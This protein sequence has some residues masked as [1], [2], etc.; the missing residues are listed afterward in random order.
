MH[1]QL[2]IPAIFLTMAACQ[3]GPKPNQPADSTAATTG[4]ATTLPD[5]W[6]KR[7]K[8]TI[9]G[10]SVTLLLQKAAPADYRGWYVYDA[11]GEPIALRPFYGETRTD[12]SIIVNEGYTDEDGVI[13]GHLGADGHFKGKWVNTKNNYDFDLTENNDSAITFSVVAFSDST[14]LLPDHPNSPSATASSYTVWPTG[15]ANEG[16]LSFLKR[17]I[18]PGLKSGETPASLLKNGADS[19]FTSYKSNASTI[20]SASMNNGPSW[21]W[22]TQS[23]SVVTW[24][25]WPILV[26]E[27]WV[28][29]FTG[30]AHGNGGSMF[31][32]YDLSKQRKLRLADVFKPN[33]KSVLTAALDK[34]YRKKYKVPASQS[35]TEGGLFVKKIEPNSNFFITSRGAVFSYTPYEIAAYAVGQ[36]TLFVPWEDIKTVVQPDYLR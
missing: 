29:E 19:F 28:Y 12:D 4:P 24:N 22:S 13:R 10:Q 6:A 21:Q 11:H 7:F 35:L 5:S 31:T 32:A 26:I 27:D 1:K 2:F 30:G 36:V 3:Q 14:K 34:S 25:Q 20:D 16:V 8:G 9:A 23:G 17:S 15:G 33:Y 18:G